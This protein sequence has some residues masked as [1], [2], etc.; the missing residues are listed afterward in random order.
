MQCFLK[1]ASENWFFLNV[2]HFSAAF[3][4]PDGA[5]NTVLT[6]AVILWGTHLSHHHEEDLYLTRTFQAACHG[7]IKP[8]IHD[9]VQLIQA[10]V[11]LSQYFFK[12]ARMMEGR[13][14]LG[15]ALSMV[16]GAGFH[17]IGSVN[18]SPSPDEG[19]RISAFW[20]VLALNNCWTTRESNVSY[21]D[22]DTPWPV[23]RERYSLVRDSHLASCSD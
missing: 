10:E 7:L 1:Y 8:C 9:I 2:D 21:D 15:R 5:L 4:D 6:N 11:L 16:F 17:K 22:I 14:H 12:N 23:E 3:L 20:T 13:Y 19:E 18:V